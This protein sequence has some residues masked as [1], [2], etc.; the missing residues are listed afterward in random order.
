MLRKALVSRVSKSA[1]ITGLAVV[2]TFFL[3]PQK[4]NAQG[5]GVSAGWS[6]VSG[7]FGMDGFTLGSSWFFSP[8]IAVT[9]NY[10]DA[11]NTD[12]VGNF[13]FTSVGAIATK[14]HI[15]DFLV[16][17][18]YFF[19]PYNINR[20]HT[21]IPFIDG[22]FGIT[23]LH[24]E[25][26]EGTVPAAIN[27]DSAFSWLLGGGVDYPLNPHWMARGELGLLRTHLNAEPQSHARIAITIAY[28]FGS[29]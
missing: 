16:G 15:Q 3:L 24:Q 11:W 14:S 12:R 5:L 13:A 25:V 20:N 4:T 29:R 7:N 22:R 19:S 9:A 28:S 10:D 23:H 18:R 17:P 2:A 8:K 21:I 6:H 27:Q 1:L 26:Q